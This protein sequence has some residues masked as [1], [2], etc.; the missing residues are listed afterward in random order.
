MATPL[1]PR[2]EIRTASLPDGGVLGGG[3]AGGGPLGGSGSRSGLT[4]M[5]GSLSTQR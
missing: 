2:D 4:R 1:G 5:D 3:A